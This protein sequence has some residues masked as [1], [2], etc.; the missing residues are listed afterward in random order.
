MRFVSFMVFSY[1]ATLF[2]VMH[3]NAPSHKRLLKTESHS[4]PT[5]SQSDSGLHFLEGIPANFSVRRLFQSQPGLY[6][7]P[8]WDDNGLIG[9]C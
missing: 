8:A 6:R 9:T 5:L 2:V 4:F 7:C 3:D 1:A